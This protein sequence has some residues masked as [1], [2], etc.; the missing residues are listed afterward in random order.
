MTDAATILAA[1]VL[2]V[3]VLCVVGYAY[4]GTRPAVRAL[5][6]YLV[7]A[8]TAAAVFLAF[9]I[10]FLRARTRSRR[11]PSPVPPPPGADTAGAA[12]RATLQRITADKAREAEREKAA[13]AVDA[14]DMDRLLEIERA[15]RTR[16]GLPPIE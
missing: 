11:Q 4:H 14:G 10:L 3:A 2:G 16:T 5:A 7:W 15:A 6:G 9:A 8:G 1:V 12:T 13:D